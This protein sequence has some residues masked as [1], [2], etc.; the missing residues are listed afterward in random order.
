MSV[1]FSKQAFEKHKRDEELLKKKAKTPSLDENP[2]TPDSN[3]KSK[4]VAAVKTAEAKKKAKE[5]VRKAKKPEFK[6][7]I[8]GTQIIRKL[9]NGKVVYI[10]S[11]GKKIADLSKWTAEKLKDESVATKLEQ[12]LKPFSSKLESVTAQLRA[13]ALKDLNN[14][15][16]FEFQYGSDKKGEIKGDR[17]ELAA[18]RAQAV[19]EKKSATSFKVTE[20]LT[21]LKHSKYADFQ[22]FLPPSAISIM[23]NGKLCI[24]MID[25]KKGER[26]G[27]FDLQTGKRV[28]MKVGDSIAIVGALDIKSQQYKSLVQTENAA[29]KR[30]VKAGFVY[31]K[32]NEKPQRIVKKSQTTQA[33]AYSGASYIPRT[34]RGSY[35]GGSSYTPA[36]APSSPSSNIP[37]PPVSSSSKAEKYD[38]SKSE[39]K[40]VAGEYNIKTV[41][42]PEINGGRN[43]HL[44]I[45]EKLDPKKPTHVIYYFH[46]FTN[47]H[48]A[49]K[50]LLTKPSQ[51]SKKHNLSGL[52]GLAKTHNIVF[53]M[54]EG[55]SGRSKWY[56]LHK[57]SKFEQFDAF[58]RK[59]S[60]A[61][62]TKDVKR[63][64]MGHS[65][66]YIAMNAILK[67]TSSNYFAG[68]G[69]F[70]TMYGK[71]LYAKEFAKRLSRHNK[72]KIW[73]LYRRVGPP[74]KLNPTL[75][76]MLKKSPGTRNPDKDIKFQTTTLSHSNVKAPGIR[77][78]MQFFLEA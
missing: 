3:K 63:Y 11:S 25:R 38:P 70:D 66:A 56:S 55:E 52:K 47:P 6:I 44:F 39:S 62:K 61:D 37:A 43:I 1:F 75:A 21:K 10:D 46:G 71:G 5:L 36:P 32:D 53:A 35:S 20:N 67:S 2:K 31:S 7:R 16:V 72:M 78:S 48:E 59:E 51:W 64:L 23:V 22:T 27:Y 15:S 77:D 29:I 74:G 19:L 45:P 28:K 42:N 24:R 50:E 34:P 54:P 33:S 14:K 65:G 49:A 69:L 41:R 30:R 76:K 12:R 57:R 17:I 58:V 8:F 60:G 13:K 73:S 9:E 18:L 4:A 40:E 26:I 68:L